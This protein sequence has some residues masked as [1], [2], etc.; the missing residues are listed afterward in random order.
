[1][2]CTMKNKE[3]KVLYY[4]QAIFSGTEPI[5]FLACSTVRRYIS[6]S[7]NNEC[8]ITSSLTSGVTDM[9][10]SFFKK[11]VHKDYKAKERNCIERVSLIFLT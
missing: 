5:S 8:I 7:Y 9:V 3:S 1:M 2:N 4:G 6:H 11:T 10:I